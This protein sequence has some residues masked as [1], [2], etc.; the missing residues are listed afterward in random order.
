MDNNTAI[1]PIPASTHDASV[2][3]L[4]DA[5]RTAQTNFIGASPEELR[6]TLREHYHR[7]FDAGLIRALNLVIQSLGSLNATSERQTVCWQKT[8]GTLSITAVYDQTSGTTAVTVNGV[9][10]CSNALPGREVLIPGNWLYAV[11]DAYRVLEA[12]K[13]ARVALEREREAEGLI[14]DMGAAV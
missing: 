14:M 13:A 4:I 1:I 7:A 6:A 8:A 12:E 10:V 3:S 9:A 11:M 5:R 2:A